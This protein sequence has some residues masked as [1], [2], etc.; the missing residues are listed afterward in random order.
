MTNLCNDN[1]QFSFPEIAA[2]LNTLLE[3]HIQKLLPTLQLPKNRYELID[4]LDQLV[5]E[6]NWSL[7]IKPDEPP[8]FEKGLAA[9]KEFYATR[10]TQHSRIQATAECLT[11]ADVEKALRD[12]S[13]REFMRA[14]DPPSVTIEFQRTTR[15]PDD[16][17]KYPLPAGLGLFPLRAVDDFIGTI[18][19]SWE[20]RGG[21]LMPMY[22]SEALWI[23]FSSR[24]PFAVKIGAGKI[25][26]VSGETWSTNLQQEP[27]NYVVL[28][29]QPWLD[30]FAVEKGVIRQF[31]AMPL[32]DGYSVEEQ[33][34]GQA[35]FG[36][37]QLQAYP[38]SAERYFLETVAPSVP[39][40][41]EELLP[42]L[43]SEHLVRNWP[44]RMPERVCE[45]ESMGLAMGGKMC[46]EIYQDPHPLAGWDQSLTRRCFVHLCNSLV[47]RQITGTNPPHPP[48]T[49]TEYRNAGI[50]WFDYYREDLKPLQ[51]SKRLAGVKTVAQLAQGKN[52]Q[53]LPGNT[54]VTPEFIIQYGNTARDDSFED[55]INKQ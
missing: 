28:P 11:Q 45:A 10:I 55:F 35:E 26:A 8:P 36:G 30:G 20:K 12:A 38:M 50:P 54:T 47:W 37:I 49:A 24:Y 5:E 39:S 48:L 32:G 1:L 31:V 19:E 15:I 27:Q 9:L 51:G 29:E 43:F 17:K 21:V 42:H 7:Q 4:A 34:T 52:G 16:G 23:G 18:P 14:D 41:I 6:S 44:S 3:K 46:Q 22:Q 53:S 13:K 40:S 33:L 2:Q 25:N